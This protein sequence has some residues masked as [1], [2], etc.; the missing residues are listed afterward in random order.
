[1]KRYYLTTILGDGSLG[2]P[3]RSAITG[4]A[5][6]HIALIA[7]RTDG[8]PRLSWALAVVDSTT[9]INGPDVTLVPTREE[10][11][12]LT[13]SERT[14]LQTRFTTYG[15]NKE[16]IDRAETWSDVLQNIVQIIF[17][18]SNWQQLRVKPSVSS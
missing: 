9:P 13:N 10:S 7:T 8:H 17:P 3:Y 18:Q 16:I 2:N 11:A 15:I 14:D 5:D 6:Q 1:M 12:A 4:L